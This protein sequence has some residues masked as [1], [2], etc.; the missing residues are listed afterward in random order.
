ML[1]PILHTFIDYHLANI[2]RVVPRYGGRSRTSEF[3]RKGTCRAAILVQPLYYIN[4][5]LHELYLLL[6][7]HIRVV[8]DREHHAVSC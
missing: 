1:A 4:P 5:L 8:L 3:F 7:Y 2:A 6:G